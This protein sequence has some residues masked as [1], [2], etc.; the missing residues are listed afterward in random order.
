MCAPE[1]KEFEKVCAASWVWKDYTTQEI[2][3]KCRA[4][5]PMQVT[6]FKKRRVMEHKRDLTLKQLGAEGATPVDT[7][8]AGG[9]A[10]AALKGR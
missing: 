7:S 8:G 6:Y 5:I 1:L 10:A 3:E 9:A 4:D 2:D